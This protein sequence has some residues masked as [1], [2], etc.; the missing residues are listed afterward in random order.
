M[1]TKKI[2]F[3]ILFIVLSIILILCTFFIVRTEIIKNEYEKKITQIKKECDDKV[4]SLKSYEYLYKENEKDLLSVTRERDNIKKEYNDYKET[5]A[6]AKKYALSR[7][8]NSINKDLR[9]FGAITVD[10]L[11][12]WIKSKAPEGSPYIGKGDVFIKAS[13]ETNLDPKYLIAH[14]VQESGWFPSQI[15][16]EKNNYFGIGSYNSSP[17]ESSYSFNGGMEAGIIGG[18]KWIKN[19][20]IDKGKYSL[21]LM[22]YGSKNGAY[23]QKDNGQ[24][25]DKWM[26][27]ILSIMNN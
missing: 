10:E 15:A 21:Y 2:N 4:V 23:C 11:N 24:P 26:Y 7:G 14:A 3:N 17:Y 25:D 16:R 18:S 8:G 20:Y 12:E 19:N 27:Q 6:I 1:K 9:D 5:V 13:K 22:Q